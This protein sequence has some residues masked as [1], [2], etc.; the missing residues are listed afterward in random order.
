MLSH[1]Q[2][3]R[4]PA[5]PKKDIRSVKISRPIIPDE[6]N[7]V[8]ESVAAIRLTSP[9]AHPEEDILRSPRSPTPELQ[10]QSPTLDGAFSPLSSYPSPEF[11]SGPTPQLSQPPP[12]NINKV[13]KSNSPC[14][15]INEDGFEE[16][17]L[18]S[19]DSRSARPE[20]DISEVPTTFSKQVNRKFENEDFHTRLGHGF[21]N[22][23]SEYDPTHSAAVNETSFDDSARN[24]SKLNRITTWLGVSPSANPFSDSEQAPA[25]RVPQHQEQHPTIHRSDKPAPKASKRDKCVTAQCCLMLLMTFFGLVSIAAVLFTGFEYMRGSDIQNRVNVLESKVIG[26]TPITLA[27]ANASILSGSSTIPA[28]LSYMIKA[29]T[30]LTPTQAPAQSRISST[31]T[32]TSTLRT[33]ETIKVAAGGLKS[34]S[35]TH[36]TRTIEKVDPYF[37]VRG[38]ETIADDEQRHRGS[39]TTVTVTSTITA[40]P[41]LRPRLVLASSSAPMETA[42]VAEASP[43]TLRRVITVTA[44][45]VIRCRD[46]ASIHDIAAH[47]SS[48]ETASTRTLTVT[49]I[50][51]PAPAEYRAVVPRF[52]RPW[53]T[54]WEGDGEGAA[55]NHVER[56][57][58]SRLRSDREAGS[59]LERDSASAFER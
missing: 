38:L 13:L 40:P 19:H 4:E 25:A 44:P 50:G 46:W 27:A 10:L 56:Q 39:T 54:G 31:C 1:L 20:S 49:A 53:R 9:Y 43:S 36:P 3:R 24:R 35:N 59:R 34:F 29:T 30:T 33:S 45:L 17:G 55:I 28:P 2:A 18:N 57:E 32:R 8:A 21:D 47:T 23:N 11:S 16:V 7:T 12:L 26:L 22:A 48:V 6:P 51:T 52:A 5:G 37:A 42:E 14:P 41:A 15:R 58:V